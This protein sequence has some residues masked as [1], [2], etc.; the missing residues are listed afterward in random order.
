MSPPA[1]NFE[2]NRVS[3]RKWYWTQVLLPATL[4]ASTWGTGAGVRKNGLFKSWQL[5]KVADSCP[6]DYLHIS[7]QAGVF[8][9]RER[10]SKTKR[11]GGGSVD[12]QALS[13]VVSISSFTTKFLQLSN[14]HWPKPCGQGIS[15]TN[16]SAGAC[17]TLIRQLL[18]Y[19]F[20]L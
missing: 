9:E 20:L 7:V 15:C 19:E 17:S 2:T 8:V 12:T 11:S 1:I 13:L 14:L 5:E 6:I 4:K 18:V 3:N 10:E 16:S